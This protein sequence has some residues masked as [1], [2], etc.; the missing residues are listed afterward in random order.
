[1][2]KFKIN[3]ILLILFILFLLSCSKSHC[4]PEECIRTDL[5]CEDKK[6][7]NITYACVDDECSP[8]TNNS[9]DCLSLDENFCINSSMMD[10]ISHDC[11]NNACVKTKKIINCNPQN[12]VKGK[13]NLNCGDNI[14]NEGENCKNCPQDV[15]C[16]EDENCLNDICVPKDQ[17]LKV[18]FFAAECDDDDPCTYDDCDR[19]KGK[20]M[21]KYFKSKVPSF[22]CDIDADCD[23]GNICTDDLCVKNRCSPE[24]ICQKNESS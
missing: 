18:C 17:E 22:C 11:R 15:S 10:L 5:Y 19:Q 9:V 6:L 12:C 20:C 16:N 4:N 21:N 23:D 13:C 2:N 1:M 24:E 3:K 8:F 7:I 14:I